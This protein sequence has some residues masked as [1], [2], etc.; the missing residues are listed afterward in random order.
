MKNIKYGENKQNRTRLSVFIH[1]N[2]PSVTIQG[3][4]TA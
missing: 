4:I 1:T 2:T 3:N